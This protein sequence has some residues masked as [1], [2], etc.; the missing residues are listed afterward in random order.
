MEWLKRLYT[1]GAIFSQEEWAVKM[2]VVTKGNMTFMEAY[3]RTGRILNIPVVPFESYASSGKMLNYITAPDVVIYTAV[4][5]SSAIPNILNPVTL[6]CKRDDG[7][8]VPYLSAGHKW[9]DGSIKNDIPER[10]LHHL[11]DV[12]YTIV[13]QTN[14][15]ILIFF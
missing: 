11:F 14:P 6:L 2:E 1:E 4:M 5:A 13:S 12:N 3:K 7:L 15:H 10:E 9:R 8:I